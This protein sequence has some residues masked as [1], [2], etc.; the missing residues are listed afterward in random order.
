MKIAKLMSRDVATCRIHD[1]LERAA[2]LM[3]DR[4]IGALPVVDDD[5]RVVGMITDRDICMATYTR[6]APPRG[7]AVTAAMAQQ[8]FS[9]GPDDSVH[10]VEK[11]MS[12]HQIR[13]MPVTDLEGHPIGLISLNDIARA[14]G[15]DVPAAEVAH[16]L[17]AVCA[18][19]AVIASS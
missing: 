5:G 10:D 15:R 9:C 19:R 7:I 12:A 13:R 14:T 3:W 1:S 17:A 6:N 18:P 16:T 8:V 11:Q 2:Q 4:D